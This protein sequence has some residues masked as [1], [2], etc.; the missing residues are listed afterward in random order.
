MFQAASSQN[1]SSLS[2]RY[3]Q[4]HQKRIQAKAPFGCDLCMLVILRGLLYCMEY[5]EESLDDWLGEELQASTRGHLHA[6]VCMPAHCMP[7]APCAWLS[8]SPKLMTWLK[9]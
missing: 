6:H 4:Q 2:C 1:T 8:C 7:Y 9:V 5:L 3:N